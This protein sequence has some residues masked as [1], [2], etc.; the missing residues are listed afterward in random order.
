M[1]FEASLIMKELREIKE[2][3][4]KILEEVKTNDN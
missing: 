1:T 3:L 2:L 4:N